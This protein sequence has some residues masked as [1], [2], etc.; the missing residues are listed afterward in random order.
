M[1]S[2]AVIDNLPKPMRE[3]ILT[4]IMAGESSSKV[5][6]LAGV[7]RQ[8]IDQYRTR[9]VRP[10]IQVA[11]KVQQS[12]EVD[13]ATISY[14][15]DTA[16]LAHDIAKASPVRESLDKYRFG[17]ETA[18]ERIAAIGAKPD[19]TAAEIAA[20]GPVARAAH[21][22]L[23]ILGEL[24]GELGNARYSQSGDVNVSVYL[25]VPRGTRDDDDGPVID[26]TPA[27]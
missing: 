9:V 25:N 6:K 7:S 2:K 14:V 13:R 17:L 4:A 10:A 24:T 27:E 16:K 22:N 3:Q 12:Q 15:R 1:A 26:I 8:A 23:R 19:A 5:A 20:I 18:L 11:A 21:E